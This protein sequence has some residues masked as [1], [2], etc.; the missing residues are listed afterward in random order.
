MDP[1]KEAFDKIKQDILLLKEQLNSITIQLN[2]LTTEN[3]S[4]KNSLINSQTN[5]THLPTQQDPLISTPTHLP[6]HEFD[7]EYSK[8]QNNDLSMRNRGVPTD[9]P[10]DRQ[11]NQ[12]TDNLNIESSYNP[13]ISNNFKES[14]SFER[15]SEILGTLDSIKKEIRL[16]F[17][18]LTP[19]EMLIFT[20]LYSLEEQD[21]GDIT[22]KVI[23]Q[24]LRLSESSVR[25]YITKLKSKGIPI[26]KNRLNN[27]QIS[28]KISSDL[29]KITN[30]PT[31]IRL[32]DI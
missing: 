13:S 18:R 22:Y 11:T 20:T 5:P 17:K 4:L 27:K 16:K 30:L 19:Q 1:I 21:I 29:K 9:K 12:Q 14:N 26:Q 24:H 10:T 23:S 25:D 15:A 31:I 8:I 32:R 6:T 3:L 28:L 7:L 2:N